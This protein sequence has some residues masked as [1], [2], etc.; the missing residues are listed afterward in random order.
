MTQPDTEQPRRTS[1][2]ELTIDA[3]DRLY[4]ERDML[5]RESDRLRKD[6]VEIRARAERAEA[7]LAENT[8]VMQALRSQ[9]D[10]AEG[11]IERVRAWANTTSHGA[12]AA[13]VLAVLDKHQ[14]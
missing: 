3:L 12:A 2:D 5:G 1:L 7:E 8:G 9:R 10:K 11:A 14:E 6:W 13:D 4:A